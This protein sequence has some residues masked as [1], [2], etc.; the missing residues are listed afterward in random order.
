MIFT[1]YKNEGETPLQAIEQYKKENSQTEKEKMTYAGRL[2]PMAEGIL[3]ILSGE[4]TKRKEEFLGL[5]KEYEF[6]ILWGISSDSFDILGLPKM[7]GEIQSEENIS[8]SISSLPKDIT[9]PYPPFSSKTIFGKP[10][11]EWFRSGKISDIEIPERKMEIKKIEAL[12]IREI[13]SRELLE[14]IISRINRVRGD[15]RQRETIEK[16]S[17]ILE[18]D[19]NFKITKLKAIVS[20]GTYIRSLAEYLGKEL[21]SGALAYRIKRVRVGEYQI[22]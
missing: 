17:E 8:D 22:D 2:D 11:F 3:L 14:E 15:F 19:K 9:L 4:D 10:L 16:W 21:N 20:S 6:E 7:G 12:G 13:E 1:I 18:K 5:E